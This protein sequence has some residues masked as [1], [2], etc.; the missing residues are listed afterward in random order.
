M[1]VSDEDLDDDVVADAKKVWEANEAVLD[2]ETPQTQFKRTLPLLL[3]M[4]VAV[5]YQ[6]DCVDLGEINLWLRSKA[7]K[8]VSQ[9]QISQYVRMAPHMINELRLRPLAK[10]LPG[11]GRKKAVKPP[12]TV[13]IAVETQSDWTIACQLSRKR[14]L[15]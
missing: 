13:F 11:Q 7:Y 6:A 2:A 14:R 8:K 9:Q 1:S 10:H 5:K 12:P 4:M 15:E 3:K